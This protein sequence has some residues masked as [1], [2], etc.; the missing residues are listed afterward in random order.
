MGLFSAGLGLNFIAYLGFAE[1]LF[2]LYYY[3]RFNLV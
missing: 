2:G 3:L 1:G